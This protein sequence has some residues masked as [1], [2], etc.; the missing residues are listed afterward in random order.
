MYHVPK[1]TNEATIDSLVP[2]DGH[3]F[4]IT[5]SEHHGISVS[6]F[7]SPWTVASLTVSSTAK[8]ERVEAE[9]KGEVCLTY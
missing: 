3:V 7:T 4:Q 9:N 6:N 2:N 1:K 5:T 8:I